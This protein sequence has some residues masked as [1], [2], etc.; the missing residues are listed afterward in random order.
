MTD[1][2]GRTTSSTRATQSSSQQA[3]FQR[4]FSRQQFPVGINYPGH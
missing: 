3:S 4:H 1:H 2:D